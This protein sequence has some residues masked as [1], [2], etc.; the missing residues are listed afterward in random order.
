MS[1]R[2]SKLGDDI[3]QQEQFSLHLRLKLP[4]VFKT[5]NRK[6][7]KCLTVCQNKKKSFWFDIHDIKK[8]RSMYF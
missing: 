6:S 3:F 7:R 5:R 2:G 1:R 4:V 8:S